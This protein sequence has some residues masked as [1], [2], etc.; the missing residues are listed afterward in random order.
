MLVA[1]AVMLSVEEG[2]D[3]E[4]WRLLH[5][6]PDFSHSLRYPQSNWALLV[7]IPEWVGLCTLQVPWVSPTYSPVRLGV[8]PAAAST[9][10]GVFTQRFEVLFP[11]AGALGCVVC[12]R[13]HQLLP[14][15]PAVA[16]P[17]ALHNLPPRW[18][19]QPLP[20][21]GVL[22]TPAAYLRPSYGSG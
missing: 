8:S 4:Q 3:R 17:A 15:W 2:S 5:S 10:I 9:P 22:F 11:C 1:A 7:L 13:V 18:V 20:C 6:L 14:R 16:L 19:C 21:L 12:H